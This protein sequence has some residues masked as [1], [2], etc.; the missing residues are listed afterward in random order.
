MKKYLQIALMLLC[1]LVVSSCSG[2]NNEL[3]IDEEWKIKNEEAFQ[4]QKFNPD[5]QELKSQS[6]NGYILYKVL[7]EGT[8]EVPIYYTSTVKVYYKGTLIDGKVFDQQ[9]FEN[10]APATFKVNE[11]VDGVTTALQHMHV[12]DKWLIWMPQQLGYGRAG[13][14]GGNVTILPY[15]TL[16]FE[17]EVTE[18][19]K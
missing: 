9:L 4:A 1:V 11:M 16:I 3:A 15:S 19:V 12:G 6:N 7:D 18:I 5:F 2:N 13:R 8:G 14:D 17:L 10:G